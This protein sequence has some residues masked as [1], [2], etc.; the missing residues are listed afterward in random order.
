MHCKNFI[1]N[2][3]LTC[4]INFTQY[5]IHLEYCG[6]LIIHNVIVQWP[7]DNLNRITMDS[8]GRRV[9]YCH[10]PCTYI[11]YAI[12]FKVSFFVLHEDDPRAIPWYF[13]ALYNIFKQITSMVFNIYRSIIIQANTHAISLIDQVQCM[14]SSC[15]YVCYGGW[16]MLCRH[17]TGRQA[18]KTTEQQDDK[19]P[20]Q[21]NRTARRHSD[22][23][24]R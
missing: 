7:K 4:F 8:G 2:T 9:G 20:R 6:S 15:I 23:K 17:E 3:I 21:N 19:L 14:F 12:W 13:P 1:T 10:G 5:S 22:A 24:R 18:D 16:F 11:L